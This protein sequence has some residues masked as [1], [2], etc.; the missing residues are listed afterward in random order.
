VGNAVLGVGPQPQYVGKDLSDVAA[1][2]I[3]RYR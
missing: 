1:Q 2:L 3:E